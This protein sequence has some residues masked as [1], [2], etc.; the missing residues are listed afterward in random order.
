[1]DDHNSY[2]PS[3]SLRSLG[4]RRVANAG[5]FSASLPLAIGS[6]RRS[7]AL[8]TS[9]GERNGSYARPVISWCTLARCAAKNNKNLF[10]SEERG[11]RSERVA[12]N[13]GLTLAR[14]KVVC[15]N[16]GCLIHAMGAFGIDLNFKRC[17]V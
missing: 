4:G 11:T 5:A 7:H 10:R 17:A 1:M 16:L 2:R 15:R 12:K 6:R 13:W 8:K 9:A 3:E 14:L